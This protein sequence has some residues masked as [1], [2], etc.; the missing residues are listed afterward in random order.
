MTLD[1]RVALVTGGGIRVGRAIV[2][3]PRRGGR[4]GRGAPPR[5]RRRGRE[6]WSPSCRS[7]DAAPRP[8]PPTSP[9]TRE[10]ERLVPE[11]ERTLGPVSVL[12]NSAARFTRA[13][14]PRHR[15]GDA[16]RRVASQCPGAL[17]P[18]PG[19]GPGNGRA[20]RGRG[21]QRPRHRRCLRPP[22]HLRR[23]RHDQGG[24]AHA[25]RAAG[26]RA[27]AAR[28]GERRRSRDR[29]PA[30][31]ARCPG[32]RAAPRPASR[33]SA[34]GVR[35]RWPRRCASWSPGRT[36]SPARSSPWTGAGSGEHAE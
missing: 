3:A 8:S 4:H 20:A 33:C 16:R 6:R 1:G 2:Q 17:P 13:D 22:P 14:L 24:D 11:V 10:L 25:H 9:T 26:R 35:R 21:G 36:S 32:A 29:P 15:R 27:G 18:H 28:P 31:V 12:V 19:G 7:G 5:L 30:R 34:S 23:L